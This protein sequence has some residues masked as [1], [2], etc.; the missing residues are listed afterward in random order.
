MD[1]DKFSL[2][3]KLRIDW[4]EL[5]Y[6]GHVNNLSFFKYIQSARVNYWDHIGLTESH[7][8]TGIGPMLVSCQC[9]FKKPLF[10]PGEVIIQSRTQFIKNTSFGFYHHLKNQQGVTVAE[11]S[12]AMVMYD[13]NSKRKVQ[14]PDELKIK[15]VM[16]VIPSD[17]LKD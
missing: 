12:D 3:L 1:S 14:F 17:R 10:Y 4:S 9:D 6:F 16:T 11:A 13:F 2:E 7:R 5:D 8:Q 15:P